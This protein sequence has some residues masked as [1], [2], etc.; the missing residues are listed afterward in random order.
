MN[1]EA[2]ITSSDTNF[3]RLLS[4]KYPASGKLSAEWHDK[5]K[6]NAEKKVED[7]ISTLIKKAEAISARNNDG[8]VTQNRVDEA[9]RDMKKGYKNS[10]L[11]VKA[12][13]LV[14]SLL[15]GIFV[16]NLFDEISKLID[17]AKSNQATGP[18]E[19]WIASY[20]AG[21]LIT[22]GLSVWLLIRDES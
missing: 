4:D 5:A 16:P 15:T 21:S 20:F 12:G 2:S 6:E 8:I 17:L 18:T 11:A 13:L 14:T 19:V 22:L 9:M 1:R 3:P 10:S 7:F